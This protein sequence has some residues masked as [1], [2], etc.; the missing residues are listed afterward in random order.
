MR[1]VLAILVV[2]SYAALGLYDLCTGRPKVGAA[3]VL[4]SIL[5]GLLFF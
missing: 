2:S 5:N 3:G 4:L 1:R